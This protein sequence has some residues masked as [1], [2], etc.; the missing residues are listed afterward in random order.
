MKTFEVSQQNEFGSV[1]STDNKDG[2]FR[3]VV[4]GYHT[5]INLFTYDGSTEKYRSDAFT[6]IEF[7]YEGVTY[8]TKLQRCY[9]RNWWFRI[10]TDFEWQCIKNLTQP[11]E[12]R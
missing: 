2:S 7:Y 11:K 10:A 5:Q 8:Y 9:H 6:T 4:Y 1:T 12:Q 3:V